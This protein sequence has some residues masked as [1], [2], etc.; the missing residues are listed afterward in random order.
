MKSTAS[1]RTARCLGAWRFEREAERQSEADAEAYSVAEHYAKPWTQAASVRLYR[2]QGVN[3][4][5][6]S[7]FNIWP[8]AMRLLTEIPVKL[9]PPPPQID[10][11]DDDI[12]F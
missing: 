5:S 4:S 12:P 2:T 9:K 11:A 7:S 6:V 10:P 8:D 1:E 3:D